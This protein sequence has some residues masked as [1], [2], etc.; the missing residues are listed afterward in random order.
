MRPPPSLCSIVSA[1]LVLAFGPRFSLGEHL[2]FPIFV[3]SIT[4]L[5][6]LGLRRSHPPVR[7]RLPELPMGRL[8]K[9]PGKDGAPSVCS[10][11]TRLATIATWET[12]TTTAAEGR[13]A[14]PGCGA[15][16][17]TWRQAS[18]TRGR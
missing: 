2:R 1:A 14:P 4:A 5:G 13:G 12:S 9:I 6:T 3:G 8:G 16:W 15:C 17:T 11:A 7:N 18:G 10:A